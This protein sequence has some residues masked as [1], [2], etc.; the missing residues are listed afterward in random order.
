MADVFASLNAM[1]RAF[2]SDE[3]NPPADYLGH[4]SSEPALAEGSPAHT[5]DTNGD[6][7]PHL[8]MN[9]SVTVPDVLER[10]GDSGI[11]PLKSLVS[12]GLWKMDTAD[13]RTLELDMAKCEKDTS[14]LE[15]A[16][17]MWHT[18]LHV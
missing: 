4:L 17:S 2:S 9:L 7:W 13:M 18:E 8:G 1:S 6:H 3:V 14:P 5:D 11:K 16:A 15:D 10:S 12:S